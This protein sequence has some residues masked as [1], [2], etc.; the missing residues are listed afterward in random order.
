MNFHNVGFI[1]L[2]LIGGSI[3]KAIKKKYPDSRII[4]H[5]KNEETICAAFADNIIDND[6]FCSVEEFG[7]CD[8]LFHCVPIQ[9]NIDYLLQL[10]PVLNQN[11]VLTDV[12][13]IK[14]DMQ[15]AIEKLHLSEQFIGGHPMTG[16]E[17][18]GYAN[19]SN[20]LLENAYYILTPNQKCLSHKCETFSDY[21]AS[22]GSIP[23][24]MSPQEHDF[25]TAAISHLP[26]ILAS[27]LVHLVKS[28]DNES[29]S[30][31]LIA[32]G[33]F[34]DITRIAS[35]SP[36][37]WQNIC[38]TNRTSILKL[39]D[40]YHN[41]F[42]VFYNAVEQNDSKALLK[43]FS[44]AKNYRDSMPLRENTS[45]L[46]GIHDFY[47]DIFDEVG[48]IA[49]IASLL[50]AHNLSIKN[51]GII[52]NREYEE[53]ILHIEMYDEQSKQDAILLLSKK[54]YMIH[55]K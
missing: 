36:V 47:C 20:L 34:R 27:S 21:I 54:H 46:P 32:A 33:G 18:I 5:A 9:I 35:S 40:L 53:G 7:K 22:L 26:H 43:L 52:H 14:G 24:M 45:M 49:M 44:E 38:L 51:I 30:M 48:G 19:S 39:M 42:H 50:A 1:G 12:G 4:A 23:L 16:S 17:K 55:S 2:G 37:M 3:A 25:D 6:T 8:L 29:E 31:K 28:L 41:Q 13:C 10:K 11:C 15:N